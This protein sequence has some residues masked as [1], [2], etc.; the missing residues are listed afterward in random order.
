ALERELDEVLVVL[1]DV[2]LEV[3]LAQHA[4]AVDVA[5]GEVLEL[6]R[7]LAE[8]EQD[9]EAVECALELADL[10]EIVGDLLE[11]ALA[12][13]QRAARFGG[14]RVEPDR[15]E[16]VVEV[17]ERRFVRPVAELGMMEQL[18]PRRGRVGVLLRALERDGG[19]H[20]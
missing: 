15:S 16:A 6:R 14:V 1:E 20:R 10:L 12:L 2:E 19:V 5:L 17:D 13:D 11:L 4:D 9:L 8:L 3:V 18:A 7:L